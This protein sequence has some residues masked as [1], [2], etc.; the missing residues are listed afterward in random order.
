MRQIDTTSTAGT[1][2]TAAAPNTTAAA[3]SARPSAY[4]FL[5]WAGGKRAL[6]P[7]IAE[8]LAKQLP[9]GG[10]RDY[11]EPFLGGGAAFFGLESQ[12][13]HSSHLADLNGELMLC[14]Q[15]IQSRVDDV[16][17]LLE[18]HEKAHRKE[19]YLEVRANDDLSDPAA[20]AARFIYLN[21][22]C[23]NGLYRVNKSGKFNVPAG[24]YSNPKICDAANLRAASDVLRT[25]TL[26]C[27]SFTETK[28]AI[29]DLVYADPPYDGTYNGYTG[30]GFGDDAQ[31]VLRDT[32]IGWANAGSYVLVSNADTRLIRSLWADWRIVRVT[33]PRNISCKANGRGNVGELLI[34]ST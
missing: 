10:F 23:F 3:R 25:A 16:I 29:G 24:S 22:T 28:P 17:G 4:P 1:V 27:G 26:R 18:E 13:H 2:M 15:M 7:H 31:E 9:R 19:H 11:H 8:Q 30:D 33:A 21:K 14:W 32:A 20:R 6:L 12:R 34:V 5:K